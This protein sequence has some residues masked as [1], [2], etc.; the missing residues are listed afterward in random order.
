MA[1]YRGGGRRT[2]GAATPEVGTTRD[3]GLEG[4]S[5]IPLSGKPSTGPGNDCWT[6]LHHVWDHNVGQRCACVPSCKAESRCAELGLCPAMTEGGTENVQRPSRGLELGR[7]LVAGRRMGVS[8]L[9]WQSGR[10]LRSDQGH[11]ASWRC[12][13][14]APIGTTF[15]YLQRITAYMCRIM[16]QGRK[17]ASQI[18]CSPPA[19]SPNEILL[20]I[21]CTTDL[22]GREDRS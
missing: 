22:T 19:R 11:R 2:A 12:V 17:R 6:R 3:G 1:G 18:V 8:R 9:W 13:A 21:S 16:H 14:R 7:A 20:S 15:S 10:G 4:L 5:P